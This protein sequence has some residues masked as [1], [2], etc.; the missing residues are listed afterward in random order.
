MEVLDKGKAAAITIIA[1]TR[2]KQTGQILF[3]NQATLFIRGAGGFG[4]R[5]TGKGLPFFLFLSYAVFERSQT[6]VRPLRSITHPL[7]TLVPL[8]R[9]RQ[10]HPRPRCIGMRFRPPQSHIFLILLSQ[11]EW[12]S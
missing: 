7:A 3:E 10:R 5:R 11:F 12:R 8:L 1:E 2:D 9:K 4:G 6:G